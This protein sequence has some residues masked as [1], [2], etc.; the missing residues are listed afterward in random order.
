MWIIPITHEASF[1]NLSDEDVD[2]LGA[3]V[4]LAL[5]ALQRSVRILLATANLTCTSLWML[6]LAFLEQLH[7][8]SF[9]FTIRTAPLHESSYGNRILHFYHWHLEVR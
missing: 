9:N 8:P 5:R 1:L 2:E 3:T 7:G 4:A 6:R